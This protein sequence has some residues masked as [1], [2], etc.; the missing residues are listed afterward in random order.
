MVTTRSQTTSSN[1]EVSKKKRKKRKSGIGRYV[2]PR[3]NN[4]K[5][6]KKYHVF[7]AE[8]KAQIEAL[9]KFGLNVKEIYEKN[10]ENGWTLRSIHRVVA[11]FKVTLK[12]LQIIKKIKCF[13]MVT[14]NIHVKSVQIKNVQQEQPRI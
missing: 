4:N 10:V 7:T 12:I 11:E 8:E 14:N 6:K 5:N 2:R 13:R 1:P 3:N 9:T